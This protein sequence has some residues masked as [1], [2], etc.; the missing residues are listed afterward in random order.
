M[1]TNK[2]HIALPEK[3]IP[4]YK[5]GEKFVCVFPDIAVYP[6]EVGKTY[7]LTNAKYIKKWE[8]WLYEIENSKGQLFDEWE[9]HAFF[10]HENEITPDENMAEN[11][12][13]FI[14]LIQFI[15]IEEN[16]RMRIGVRI[17][18]DEEKFNND[19]SIP[20]LKSDP[21]LPILLKKLKNLIN[22][23]QHFPEYQDKEYEEYWNFI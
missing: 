14:K 2:G 9:F 16:D 22:I 20:D 4:E 8:M 7:T 23:L 10:K 6:I 12:Q 5:I 13:K 3:P 15:K 19:E 17:D 11:I 18:F 1:K 21:V